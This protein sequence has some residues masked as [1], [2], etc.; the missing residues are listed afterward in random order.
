MVGRIMLRELSSTPELIMDAETRT[1]LHT[2]LEAIAAILYNQTEPEQ[3][4][5]L[6]AIEQTVRQQMLEYVSPEVAKFLSTARAARVQG[7]REPLK[8]SSET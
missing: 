3:V 8:V 7:E 1:Q 6:E 2:H 4:A 5:T